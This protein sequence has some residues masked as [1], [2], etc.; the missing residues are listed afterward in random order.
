MLPRES[1]DGA[2]RGAR[3]VRSNGAAHASVPV[4]KSSVA[5]L[6]E[7]ARRLPRKVQR[8]MAARPVVVLATVGGAAFFAGAVLGSRLGR[9]VLFAAIP[10]GLQHLV[11]TELGPRLWTYMADLTGKADT[12]PVPA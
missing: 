9:A 6:V 7:M 5:E 12:A 1:V 2:R 11:E 4:G 10:V 3:R 8:E